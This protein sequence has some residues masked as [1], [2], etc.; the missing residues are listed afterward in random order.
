VPEPL[1][2]PE[3]P[4]QFRV[5]ALDYSDFVGRI[6]IGRVHRGKV[7]KGD[8][9]MQV[10]R[11]G[12]RK[13][14]VVRGLY[15][16]EGLGRVETDM[17]QAGDLTALYGLEQVDI[18]DSLTDID[19]VEPLP[20]IAVDEPT[21]NMV[22]R[23]NDSPFAGREGKYVTS[24][25]VRER[26][27]REILTNVALRVDP[28]DS[29]DSFSVSGRGILHLGILIENMRR[30]GFEFA[31]SKPKVILQER[32][33][34]TLEPIEFLVIDCPDGTQ[35]KVIEALGGRRG[36][37]TNMS[38]KGT[39]QHLEFKIPARGLI[40]MRTRIMNLTS[41]QAIMHHN[42]LEY[43]EWR[44]ALPSR[45]SGVMVTMATGIAMT[46]AIEGLR[47]RGDFFLHPG[48]EIYEGMIVGEH[49]K[50]GDIVVN[51]TREKKMTN[52][53]SSNKEIVEKLAVPRLFSVEEALEYIEDDEL[54]EF[55]P[56]TVRLRKMVLNEKE[57]RKDA[58]EKA[59]EVEG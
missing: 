11:H 38:R 35:G 28:T 25:H 42:F 46:Y 20:P 40:G 47:D 15:R 23:I 22:F 10:T 37:L 43:G 30:E 1:D 5:S 13:P 9:V 31:V 48:T 44:G 8:Q 2:D 50:E 41:G 53:R 58:R 27:A 24:R 29:P 18:G 59:A 39:F 55:T 19:V 57:R 34:E 26:L 21:L 52:V 45:I 32:G 14:A 3:K 6:A 33:G 56:K 17:V 12:D 36:E 49:C 7:R 4:L 51:L 16:F 54:A